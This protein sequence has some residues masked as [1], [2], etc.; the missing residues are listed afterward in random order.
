MDQ[1][2]LMKYGIAAA[3]LFAAWK[4]G[5]SM[6]KAAAVAV[7]AVAVARRTPYVKEVL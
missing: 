1:A 6:G 3:V 5:G 2:T 4:Y 7:G